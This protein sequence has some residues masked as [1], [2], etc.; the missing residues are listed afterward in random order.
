MYEIMYFFVYFKCPKKVQLLLIV[1]RQVSFCIWECFSCTVGRVSTVQNSFAL[2]AAHGVDLWQWRHRNM[3]D[4]VK[5]CASPLVTSALICKH[6]AKFSQRLLPLAGLT[7]LCAFTL[8][9][10]VAS[11]LQGKFNRY[12][13][14]LENC[15]EAWR[16]KCLNVLLSRSSVG[17]KQRT[18][19]V[20]LISRCLLCFLQFVFFVFVF[21]MGRARGVWGGGGRAG[22]V[23]SAP[24]RGV[25]WNAAVISA[26]IGLGLFLKIVLGINIWTGKKE[27][28]GSS[29]TWVRRPVLPSH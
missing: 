7:Q 21:C 9:L 12:Y 8:V 13:S 2:R 20:S 29:F 3:C 17:K 11:S 16:H 18:Y 28:R 4:W 25:S 19:R 15:V 10:G 5:V 1:F 23:C 26:H 27:R 24:P 22:L 6:S 14:R